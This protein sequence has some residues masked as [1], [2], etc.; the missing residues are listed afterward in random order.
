MWDPDPRPAATDLDRGN[1]VQGAQRS[2]PDATGSS[3]P[4]AR[5]EPARP[6]RECCP[7]ALQLTHRVPQPVQ[8]EA[9]DS[10]PGAAGSARAGHGPGPGGGSQPQRAAAQH[11]GTHRPQ[12]RLA[13]VAPHNGVRQKSA[14][15]P[16]VHPEAMGNCGTADVFGQPFR[17]GPLQGHAVVVDPGLAT[18]MWCACSGVRHAS[19][20]VLSHGVRTAG[21]IRA[22]PRFIRVE[23]S[24]GGCSDVSSSST[25]S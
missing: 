17:H 24:E 12:H 13:G 16:Q 19:V 22:C 6:R 9:G 2:G 14:A 25:R 11:G 8:A 23:P 5:P 10:S 20:F 3:L 21:V 4:Q 7:P 1:A 18:E 15:A